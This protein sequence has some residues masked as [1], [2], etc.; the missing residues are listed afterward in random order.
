[1]QFCPGIAKKLF[2]FCKLIPCW[3]LLMVPIF[4]YGSTTESSSTS[5]SLFKD[6]KTVVFK[7]KSLPLRIDD[8]LKIH[9]N[10]IIGSTN[11]LATKRK[12]GYQSSSNDSLNSKKEILEEHQVEYSLMNKQIPNLKMNEQYQT[13]AKKKISHIKNQISMIK[14]LLKIGKVWDM[15]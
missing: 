3:S 6:L 10:S 14:L 2:N 12:Y 9:I 11:M 7:H 5:E 15:M 8:F 1:M 13:P 4:K